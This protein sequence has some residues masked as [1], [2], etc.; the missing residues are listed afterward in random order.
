MSRKSLYKALIDGIQKTLCTLWDKELIIDSNGVDCSRTGRS[1]YCITWSGRSDISSI[2]FDKDMKSNELLRVLLEGKQFTCVLFDRSIFQV[3]YIVCGSNVIKA[4]L[5]FLKKDNIAYTIEQVR[6]LETD[7]DPQGGDWFDFESGIPVMIRI[8]YDFN[9]HEDV[10]HPISHISLSNSQTCRIPAKGLIP[11][12]SFCESIM[13][14]F[15]S[16][17]LPNL[18]RFSSIPTITENEQK[19]LHINWI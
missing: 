7:F 16:I 6:E 18:T 1:D 12:S 8:D 13:R 14:Q 9:N 19:I 5:L 10:K 2:T 11:F 17:E 4:R 3:E 15:Y